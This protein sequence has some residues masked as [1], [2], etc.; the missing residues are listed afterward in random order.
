MFQEIIK[1]ESKKWETIPL[2]EYQLRTARARELME[3]HEMDA[4]ILFSPVNWWYYGGWTD[5]AQMHNWVW[6]SCMIV[7]QDRDPVVLIHGA[8]FWQVA[9]TTYVRDIRIWSETE[10]GRLL[11]AVLLGLQQIPE[12]FWSTLLDTLKDL[13]LDKGVLGIEKGP[14]IDT[15]LS[16][17]EYDLLGT[18]IP[19]AKIVSADPVI[20][21]QRTVKTPYEIEIIREGCRRACT[22][23]KAAFESIKSGVNEL[24][25]HRTFWKA[26]AGQDLLSTPNQSTWLCWSS[27]ASEMG[28][29]HRWI[30]GPVDRIIQEG[31]MGLSDCGPSYRG[32][33]MDF[34]RT[35]YVGNP[36]QKEIDLSKMACEAEQ[37][38]IEALKPGVTAGDVHRASVDA[39]KK[40]DPGQ[41][42][43]INFVG[44][45]MGFS[46]HEPP[47]VVPDD[48]TVI[49]ENMVFCIEVGAF[50]LEMKYLGAM[51]ED[52][53]LV[54]RDGVENLTADFSNELFIA[55]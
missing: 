36:P 12:E 5:V 39:L 47:W 28:G 21:E 32:Y 15:Y 1:S 54:K 27:S 41:G 10:G 19:G 7:P 13:K 42:H 51:P 4:M 8:F 35:F 33:Q 53:V 9:L 11:G 40:L 46:N 31:D 17:E 20:W 6:R 16:F 14:D 2:S 52:I 29:V 24:D 26:C 30:T 37:A 25:V 50:D 18:R 22:V 48:P 44:H 38:T 34:Q 45:G 49:R 55:K 23:V 43:I 3:K